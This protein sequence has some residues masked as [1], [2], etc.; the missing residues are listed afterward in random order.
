MYKDNY[1]H[2]YEFNGGNLTIKHRNTKLT[3]FTPEVDI[4]KTD[5][6]KTNTVKSDTIETLRKKLLIFIS[7]I[8]SARQK[9]K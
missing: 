4:V 9:S 7:C 8:P 6:A 2:D 3:D 1:T 5:D